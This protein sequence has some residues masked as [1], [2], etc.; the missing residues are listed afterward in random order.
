MKNTL[1]DKAKFFAQYWGQKVL[2][3]NNLGMLIPLK[4]K[5]DQIQNGYLEL[6]S[7]SQISNEDAIE[8]GKVLSKYIASPNSKTG[9]EYYIALCRNHIKVSMKLCDFVDKARELGY[10]APYNGVSV[11]TLIEWRWIRLK[12]E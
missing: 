8:L 1:E 5:L 11:E 12:K 3:I 6:K 4:V 7:L 9:N 2:K 10:A